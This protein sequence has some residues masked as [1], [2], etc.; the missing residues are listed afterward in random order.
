MASGTVFIFGE[1]SG[2]LQRQS[3]MPKSRHLSGF[4][5]LSLAI[6]SKRYRLFC[7]HRSSS[8]RVAVLVAVFFFPLFSLGGF[9]VY[10]LEDCL[11]DGRVGSLSGLAVTCIGSQSCRSQGLLGGSGENQ[12]GPERA[13]LGEIWGKQATGSAQATENEGNAKRVSYLQA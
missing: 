6:A 10:L 12:R 9:R 13:S 3:Q 5:R 11:P 2:R 7:A 1:G 4:P 8:R